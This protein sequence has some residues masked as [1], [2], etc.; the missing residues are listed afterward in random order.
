M[1]YRIPKKQVHLRGPVFF[2]LLFQKGKAVRD[3]TEEL[4]DQFKVVFTAELLESAGEYTANLGH[5][6]TE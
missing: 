6:R 2:G 5:I 4:D 1:N 3:F